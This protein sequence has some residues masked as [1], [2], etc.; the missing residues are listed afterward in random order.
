MQAITD[1]F[2]PQ[3]TAER[4]AA[5]EERRRAEILMDPRSLEE[6]DATFKATEVN[7]AV[8]PPVRV[9]ASCRRRYQR[10]IVFLVLVRNKPTQSTPRLFF[11]G[12]LF[13]SVAQYMYSLFINI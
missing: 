2:S 8:V 5:A 3:T 11:L 7:V 12:S 10:T 6:K 1:L 9:V 4:V 13:E